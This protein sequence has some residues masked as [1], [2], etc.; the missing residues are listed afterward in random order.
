[1]IKYGW[2]MPRCSLHT[3]GLV[4][5]GVWV[6]L[7]VGCADPE[8]Q[9]RI[10]QRARK[11][12]KTIRMMEEIEQAHPR[13]LAW[14]VGALEE[15]HVKDTQRSAENPAKIAAFIE[16]DF[17]RFRERQPRYQQDFDRELAGDVATIERT[18]PEIVY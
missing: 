6:T 14:A 8:G 7:L 18:W 12:A 3:G 15:Y 5:A 11:L 10:D 1:M 9:A 17:Q 16:A 2:P 4:M 13:S